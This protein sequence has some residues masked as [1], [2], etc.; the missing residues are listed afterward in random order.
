[1]ARHTLYSSHI[2]NLKGILDVE[3]YVPKETIAD[4]G[5]AKV[6]LRKTFAAGVKSST[7][8]DVEWNTASGAIEMPLGTTKD[9]VKFTFARGTQQ[10]CIV[11]LLVTVVDT[12]P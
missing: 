10:M 4:T 11:I 5:A 12:T 6:M 1:M 9:K 2:N 7:H 3:G 8:S